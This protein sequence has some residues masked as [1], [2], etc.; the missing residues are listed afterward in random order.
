MRNA[1]HKVNISIIEDSKIH[2]EWLNEQFLDNGKFEVVSLDNLGRAGIESV[3]KCHPDM[4][5]LDFQLPDIT[6]LEVAKR[7]KA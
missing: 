2:T 4:V 1:N 7:I 3:K 6:G 5:L